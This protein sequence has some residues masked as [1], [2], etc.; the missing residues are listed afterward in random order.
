MTVTDDEMRR[1]RGLWKHVTSGTADTLQ[2]EAAIKQE[3][4]MNRK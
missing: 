1:Q 3:Q 4:E 2:E